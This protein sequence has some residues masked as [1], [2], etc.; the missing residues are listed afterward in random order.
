MKDCWV[1][2]CILAILVDHSVKGIRTLQ[3]LLKPAW[4]GS[5]WAALVRPVKP[6]MVP[7]VTSTPMKRMPKGLWY[8][9]Y[10]LK[11]LSIDSK[12]FYKRLLVFIL[13]TLLYSWVW[14]HVQDHRWTRVKSQEGTKNSF[15]QIFDLAKWLMYFSANLATGEWANNLTIITQVKNKRQQTGKT[16]TNRGFRSS[17]MRRSHFVPSDISTTV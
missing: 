12:T 14:L 15:E 5:Y 17:Q 9:K 2:S 7:V 8:T 3:C 1:Y 10:F 16:K 11:F 13:S 4:R 6:E